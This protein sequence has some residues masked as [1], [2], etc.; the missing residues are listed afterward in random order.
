M[1]QRNNRW[2]ASVL[3]VVL[4]TLVFIYAHHFWGAA[5]EQAV[6]GQPELLLFLLPGIFMALLQPER[7]LLST[8]WVALGGTLLGMVWLILA[9]PMIHSGLLMVAWSLS[10]LFWAGCGALLIRLLR[11]MLAMR[12]G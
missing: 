2:P 9:T 3:G 7:P 12:A 4:Y 1:L 8:L 6:R 11:I 10:A 5:S